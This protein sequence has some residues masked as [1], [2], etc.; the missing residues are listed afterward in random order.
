MGSNIQIGQGGWLE[1]KQLGCFLV[2]PSG[3]RAAHRLWPENWGAWG[4]LCLSPAWSEHWSTTHRNQG[5]N[6]HFLRGGW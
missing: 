4:C 2:A 5:P 6:L 3:F 1:S